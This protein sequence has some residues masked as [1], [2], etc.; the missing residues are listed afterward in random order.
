MASPEG[1]KRRDFI[2]WLKDRKTLAYVATYYVVQIQIHYG[3]KAFTTQYLSQGLMV[4]NGF[5]EA[6]MEL[7]S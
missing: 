4:L 5:I 7:K 2:W 6:S 3:F 1:L